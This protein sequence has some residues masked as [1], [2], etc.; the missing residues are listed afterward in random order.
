MQIYEDEEDGESSIWY[1]LYNNRKV[2]GRAHMYFR[3][4]FDS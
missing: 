1:K 3:I 2:K 4:E